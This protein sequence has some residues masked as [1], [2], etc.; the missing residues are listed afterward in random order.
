PNVLAYE[1]RRRTA[2]AVGGL[3]APPER[4]VDVLSRFRQTMC[5][6]G[7]TRQ[8]LF[9]LREDEREDAFSA[10]FRSVQV[11][12]EAWLDLDEFTLTGKRWAH[13]RQMNNRA[14]A[15]GVIVEEADLEQWAEE[16]AAVHGEWLTSKR[17]SWRMKLLIGSPGFERPYD[18]RYVVAHADGELQG[19]CTVLPGRDGVWGLDV[20]CRRPNAIAGTMERLIVAV[21]Q[22]LR[23]EG[24][25]QLSLG[26]CPMA[27]VPIEGQG[28]WLKRIFHVLYHSWIGNQVFGFASLHRFKAK[29]RPRWEPVYFAASP[30]IGPVAL[31]RGCRMWGL[32]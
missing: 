25:T 5:S 12:V 26:P 15:R 2:F 16:M 14:K 3:N 1:A 18:R 7:L 27:G 32:Y 23:D 6:R 8:M 22:T 17:P 19:F 28:Q 10:G 31:Y 30:K 4:R 11:G 24:A 29:F 9:P 21:G 20:M 13:V